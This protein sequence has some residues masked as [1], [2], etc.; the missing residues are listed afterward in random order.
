MNT[1]LKKGN[2]P[3]STS[4]DSVIQ[5][6]CTQNRLDEAMDFYTEMLCKNLK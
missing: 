2:V 5:G 6:F 4:Y 3:N 1:M